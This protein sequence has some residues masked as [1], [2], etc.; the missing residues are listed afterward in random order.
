VLSV[1]QREN[2]NFSGAAFNPGSA[3]VVSN[4]AWAEPVPL[5]QARLP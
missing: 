5:R 2:K 1:L 3:V 4:T